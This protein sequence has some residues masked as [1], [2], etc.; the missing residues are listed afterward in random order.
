MDNLMGRLMDSVVFA[1]SR[2]LS[3]S[4]RHHPNSNI[5]ITT[6]FSHLFLHRTVVVCHMPGW[7]CSWQLSPD[8]KQCSL[9]CI[10]FFWCPKICLSWCLSCT[11]QWNLGSSCR[12]LLLRPWFHTLLALIVVLGCG[13]MAGLKVY[14]WVLAALY[15]VGYRTSVSAVV[16]C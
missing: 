3:V 7:H 16:L 1:S 9:R 15:L 4:L 14:Y 12:L 11:C 5:A 13:I 10:V 6:Q 2:G 8:K